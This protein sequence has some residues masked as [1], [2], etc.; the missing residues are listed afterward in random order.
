MIDRHELARRLAFNVMHYSGLPRVFSPVFSGI[1][2]I[3][4]LHRVTACASTLPGY[5]R[6]LSVTPSFLDQ[7]LTMLEEEGYDIV[8]MDDVKIRITRPVHSRPF[9]A[10]T[11]DDG[12]RDNLLEALPVFE[13]HSAPFTVYV[14]PGLI[15][16]KVTL[17]WNVLEEIVSLS[18]ALSYRNGGHSATLDC[19]SPRRKALAYQTLMELVTT[20]MPEEA[21]QDFVEELAS[22]V[23]FD[24]GSYCRNL[25]MNWQEI[26]TIAAHPQCTIGAHTVHHFNLKRLGSE[27]VR[28]E[29]ITGRDQLEKELNR[30]VR[31]FAYPYGYTQAVGEREVRLA[32][33]AGF[34]TAV[35]TR[36]GVIHNAHANHLTALPRISVNGRYQDIAHVRTMLSGVT[37]VL[38]AKGRRIVTV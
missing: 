18:M 20:K 31:H 11:L 34:E 8:A 36:H 35:T 27:Q 6:H 22:A 23:G 1:G 32:A 9:I 24:S 19:S 13:K 12:Y 26:L 28:E 4:M 16:G 3:L 10:I 25:L 7:V 38:A 33:E 30:E 29:M 37:S 14:A 17:W 21:Q 2:A 15:D 5:N